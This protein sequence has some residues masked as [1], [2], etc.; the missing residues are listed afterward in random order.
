[1]SDLPSEALQHVLYVSARKH[2]CI[3]VTVQ[4]HSQKKSS[5]PTVARAELHII[6]EISGATGFKSRQPALSCKWR[7]IYD[8]HKS[9][10]VVRGQQV[11]SQTNKHAHL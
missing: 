8:T 10:A 1:V 9:W 6:G 2:T 4:A 7:L 11:V 3:L 5:R